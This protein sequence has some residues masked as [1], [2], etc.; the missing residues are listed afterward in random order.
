MRLCYFTNQHHCARIHAN[1]FDR[2]DGFLGGS[3]ILMFPEDLSDGAKP[4]V[5]VHIPD[6]V[7]NTYVHH[8]RRSNGRALFYRLPLNVANLYLRRA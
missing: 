6:H 5:E 3:T 2:H 4:V 7:A 1:G 8:N